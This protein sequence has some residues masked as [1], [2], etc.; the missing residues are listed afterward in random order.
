MRATEE[1]AWDVPLVEFSVFKDPLKSVSLSP[2]AKFSQY[3]QGGNSFR[4]K[5]VR[6]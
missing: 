2:G 5:G 6:T 3:F 1:C 4:F